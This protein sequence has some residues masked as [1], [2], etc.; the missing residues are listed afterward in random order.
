M[1]TENFKWPDFPAEVNDKLYPKNNWFILGSGILS[2][3]CFL[4]LLWIQMSRDTYLFVDK[5]RERVR[6]EDMNRTGASEHEM[7]V[8]DSSVYTLQV[9]KGDNTSQN[10]HQQSQQGQTYVQAVKGDSTVL[11]VRTDY[12]VTPE[13]WVKSPVL[14]WQNHLLVVLV[15]IFA[16]VMWVLYY[17]YSISTYVER[18]KMMDLW[19]KCAIE[20]FNCQLEEDRIEGAERKRKELETEFE[21]KKVERQK[22]N[23]RKEAEDLMNYYFLLSYIKQG[24]PMTSETLKE[25]RES[26]EKEYKQ[27][28][29]LMHELN[30]N[31]N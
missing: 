19:R 15:G 23:A 18:G 11:A 10:M 17:K 16:L 6:T 14:E 2:T 9:I 28:K 4:G 26:L 25:Y 22:K 13:N 27:A 21:D 8:L 7:I 12:Y 29:S 20:K 31:S 5:S 24:K 3:L 1:C 30:N